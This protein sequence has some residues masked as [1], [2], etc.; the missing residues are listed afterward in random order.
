MTIY[1]ICTPASQQNGAFNMIYRRTFDYTYT[2]VNSAN[3]V[4]PTFTNLITSNI[5][6]TSYYNTEGYKQ[7]IDFTIV[8]T[9]LNVDANM[10]W[11]VNFPSYYSPQLFQE[12]SYCLIDSAVISCT[13]DPNTPYQLI[14]SGSPKTNNAGV[15]YTITIVGLACPRSLYT[16]NAYPSRYIFM[17]VLENSQSTSFAERNL[18]LP[19]QNIQ[20]MVNG[21]TNV[22][23]M[24]GVSVSSLYS[25]SSLYAQFELS[26][27]VAITSGS[28]LYIDLPIQFDNLN[29][30]PLN[31]ILTYTT[32]VISSSTLI[33]NRKIQIPLTLN[34]P[35]QTPFSIQIPSLPTPKLPCSVQM[36]EII[37]TITPSDKLSIYSA[38]TVQGNSAPLLTFVKNAKYISFNNDNTIQIT[39]GTYSAP[40]AI[41]ASDNHTF[42]SNINIK[43][44][45]TGF[46]FIPSNVFLP[47]GASQG[48]FVVGAD[49]SLIPV[50]YFYQAIK[51]E[52]VNT[53]YQITLNMN[54]MVTNTP[55]PITLPTS[56]NMPLGGCTNPFNII[57]PNPPF[58]DLTISYTFNNT[59]YSQNDFY[60]NP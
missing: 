6:M 24:V 1:G 34:I 50:V 14:I 42:L 10:V 22:L 8:N 17:G 7:E 40:I 43:L 28:Y 15:P 55:A 27:T 25:F 52:E 45:S 5:T 12:D 53:N 49:S 54:I 18:L 59:Q 26:S 21:V 60:P 2:I 11:I 58:L 33:K 51:Q 30:I 36:S 3:V 57:L 56:L 20:S 4:F 16:N 35:P 29:N 9:E 31:A 19:Y 32:N 39:A 23:D 48:S 38:S 37:V 41:T 44:S 46:T 47:I 13:V